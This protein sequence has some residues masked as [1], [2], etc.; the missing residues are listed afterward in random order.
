MYVNFVGGKKPGEERGN[1]PLSLQKLAGRLPEWGFSKESSRIKPGTEIHLQMIRLQS[2][3]E[4]P[5]VML[6]WAPESFEFCGFFFF[7]LELRGEKRCTLRTQS[8]KFRAANHF[9]RLGPPSDNLPKYVMAFMK[10][11]C[12]LNVG[13]CSNS[14]PKALKKK[15]KIIACL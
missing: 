5:C 14:P 2:G 6:I 3:V 12:C 8:W 4:F 7:F 15:K 9:L 10:N 13:L 11:A 1:K